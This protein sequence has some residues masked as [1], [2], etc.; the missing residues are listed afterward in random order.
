[1]NSAN[2]MKTKT[3]KV[4][5]ALIPLIAAGV[6]LVLSIAAGRQAAVIVEWS[7]ASELDTAGFNVY[8]GISA[9]LIDQKVNSAVIPPATDPLQGGSYR[10][11][12]DQVVPGIR[13]Y[14]LI[15]EV[16]QSGKTSRYGP[17]E[18]A[19]VSGGKFELVLAVLLGTSGLLFLLVLF[20][21]RQRKQAVNER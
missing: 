2:L 12:D 14:Y 16:D 1:M 7:T 21:Q 10:F 8:R 13:Y 3:S 20:L 15:E 18:V 17:I 19:A 6:F 5:V 4:W 11:R 9:D